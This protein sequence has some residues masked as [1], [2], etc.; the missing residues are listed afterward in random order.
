M[1]VVRW[2]QTGPWNE[3]IPKAD[4][5]CFY[6]HEPLVYPLIYWAGFA[7]PAPGMSFIGLHP[8]CIQRWVGHLLQ[9][10]NNA[11][12]PTR[13]EDHASRVPNPRDLIDRMDR[14]ED[15][16]GWDRIK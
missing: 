10:A 2:E 6:C 7:N 1:G 15:S 4:D 13:V 9:D 14:I 12:R 11:K 5:F 8:Q 3:G 16:D